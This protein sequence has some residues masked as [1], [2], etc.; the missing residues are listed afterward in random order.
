MEQPQ[1]NDTKGTAEQVIF[2]T[3][4][5]R[6]QPW[7]QHWAPGAKGDVADKLKGFKEGQTI[8]L[9]GTSGNDGESERILYDSKAQK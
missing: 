6:T 7:R 5:G 2:G 8:A 1:I 9:G 3:N 4:D